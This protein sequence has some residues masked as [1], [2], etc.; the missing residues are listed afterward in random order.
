MFFCLLFELCVSK[1]IPL[2]K[3]ILIAEITKETQ[4]FHAIGSEY[5]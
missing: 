5:S 1:N 2:K 3:A 4:D